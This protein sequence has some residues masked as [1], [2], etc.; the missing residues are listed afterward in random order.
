MAILTLLWSDV[1]RYQ[2]Q[3]PLEKSWPI[4]SPPFGDD[5]VYDWPHRHVDNVTFSVHLTQ[6]ILFYITVVA[7]SFVIKM[8][9]DQQYLSLTTPQLPFVI[10]TT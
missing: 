8:P 3:K 2:P 10:V 9:A 5:V 1:I 4:P 7:D 6:F